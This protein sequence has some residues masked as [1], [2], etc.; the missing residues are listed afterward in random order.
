M[1]HHFSRKQCECHEPTS[2]GLFAHVSL[3]KVSKKGRYCIQPK[4]NGTNCQKKFIGKD[5]RE[6]QENI[7]ICHLAGKR[8]KKQ[9]IKTDNLFR[10]NELEK[11]ESDEQIRLE[12]VEKELRAEQALDLLWLLEANSKKEIRLSERTLKQNHK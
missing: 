9:Q 4:F 6:L 7:N 1:S 2:K 3:L 5:L 12:K 10:K 11:V 8:L